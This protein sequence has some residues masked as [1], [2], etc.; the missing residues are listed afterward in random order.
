MSAR[1]MTEFQVAA[2]L[3]FA[4]EFFR[5]QR[6]ALEAA[7]FPAPVFPVPDQPRTRCR[8]WSRTAVNQWID[9]PVQPE[10]A[11]ASETE[12]AQ[13]ERRRRLAQRIAASAA[14]M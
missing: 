4:V 5:R 8:R 14:G 7:G 6:P 2:A 10:T 12:T 3:D 1:T 9:R 13:A 11:A